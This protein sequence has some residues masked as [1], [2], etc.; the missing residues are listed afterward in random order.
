VAQPVALDAAGQR[1]HRGVVGGAQP[2][3][4]RDGGDRDPGDLHGCP[5]EKE[6]SPTGRTWPR[7]T[8][9]F[10]AATALGT[11]LGE[12]IVELVKQ[13]SLTD[14]RAAKILLRAE[15]FTDALRFQRDKEE[16]IAIHQL[17]VQLHRLAVESVTER[18]S[19]RLALQ[20]SLHA[21]RHR[22]RSLANEY[23]RRR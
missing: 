3:G 14:I 9:V 10:G 5:V 4:D 22:R 17:R 15:S 6:A 7:E 21:L 1:R 18:V 2:A 16:S 12:L 23:R 13:G 8:P 19:G 11:I 20:P